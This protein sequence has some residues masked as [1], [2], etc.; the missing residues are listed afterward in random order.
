MFN[1]K[2][3]GTSGTSCRFAVIALSVISCGINQAYS[4]EGLNEAPQAQQKRDAEADS[5]KLMTAEEF[6]EA[7]NSNEFLK[8]HN[9]TGPLTDGELH[10]IKSSQYTTENVGGM[11]RRN[12]QEFKGDILLIGGERVLPGHRARGAAGRN[13]E[14][15]EIWYAP[16][17]LLLSKLEHQKGFLK[18]LE[19]PA[20]Q[21]NFSDPSWPEKTRNT[22]RELEILIDKY[23]K[24]RD[25]V[26][27]TDPFNKYYVLNIAEEVEPDLVASIAS[28]T[29]TQS[30]PDHHFREV[31]FE[32][33]DA[34]V[35]LNPN[36]LKIMERVA[37]PGGT[38]KI[39]TAASAARLYIIVFH[40]T[41]WESE[42]EKQYLNQKDGIIF[43]MGRMEFTLVN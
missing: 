24:K 39:S 12:L 17:P 5:V 18:W 34:F 10:Q 6:Q 14:D 27:R 31:I 1:F 26:L 9:L 36:T 38:I 28:L 32:N 4:M 37:K 43:D 16:N 30:I 15:R 19:T 2:L 33:V 22:I 3:S 40:G 25:E 23:D 11:V 13:Q 21:E 42:I 35:F 7:I 29:D 20:A 8:E 41:K